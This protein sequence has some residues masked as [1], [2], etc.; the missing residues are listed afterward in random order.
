MTTELQFRC[1]QPWYKAITYTHTTVAGAAE[2]QVLDSNPLWIKIDLFL[3]HS[4]KSANAALSHLH[5]SI[6]A[7]I[8][9][10]AIS[11][12][13]VYLTG[14]LQQVLTNLPLVAVPEQNRAVTRK[15]VLANPGNVTDPV[16]HESWV[17][18][19]C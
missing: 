9:V 18:I 15:Q 4:A 16:L 17:D 5:A 6:F 8:G 14:P 11:A 12:T 2:I 7:T 1:T 10:T 3:L 13:P 19:F